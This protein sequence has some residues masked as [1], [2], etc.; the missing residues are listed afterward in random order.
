MQR[1][2][3]VAAPNNNVFITNQEFADCA[4]DYIP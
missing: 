1:K 2:S 3:K 4:K